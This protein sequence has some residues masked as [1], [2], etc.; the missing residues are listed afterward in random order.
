[1]SKKFWA[2]L[3]F[4]LFVAFG[5]WDID[6]SGGTWDEPARYYPGV[7]YLSNWKN[8]RFGEKDWEWFYEHPP[9]SKYIYGVAAVATEKWF[10]DNPTYPD[11]NYTLTRIFSVLMTGVTLIFVLSLG[12]EF[13]SPT[14]GVLAAVLFGLNPQVLAYA[15][16]TSLESPTLLFFTA[17]VYFFLRALKEGGNS[18]TYLTAGLMTGLAF[19]TRFS[20]FLLMPLFGVIIVISQRRLLRD[21]KELRLPLNLLFAFLLSCSVV[22]LIWPWLWPAPF[23]RFMRSLN[24]WQEQ[25]AG[26]PP[27]LYYYFQYFLITTPA[28]LFVFL[29]A[30][31]A[32][33]RRTKNFWLLVLVLWFLTPFLFTFAK[34]RQGGIRLMIPI[35]APLSLMFAV[36]LAALGEKI[37]RLKYPFFLLVPVYL[38][39]LDFSVHPYYLDFFNELIG[40]PRGAVEK[41][42]SLMMW[43]EGVKEA[44]DFVNETAPPGATFQSAAVPLHAIPML[45]EDLVRFKPIIATHMAVVPPWSDNPDSYLLEIDRNELADYVVVY[46]VGVE[47]PE[48]YEEVY[49]SRVAGAKLATV[50]ELK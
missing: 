48:G 11:W 7:K 38:L 20:N 33:L 49:T 47:I 24:F 18:K 12:W 9:V 32:K 34:Y 22:Y 4:L 42:T 10:P 19:S 6:G 27:P 16:N 37:K 5:V 17:A 40:G 46:N 50:Y 28:L 1:M 23:D 39:F 29:V 14:V 31:F 43:G 41:G 35:F 21:K 25:G 36:G 8:L 26:T 30:F 13:F 2:F 45:R 3:L 15:K 44:V